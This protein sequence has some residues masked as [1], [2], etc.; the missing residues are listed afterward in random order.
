LTK[1]LAGVLVGDTKQLPPTVV[2]R[3]A[4]AIGLQRSLIERLELLGVEPY[5]LE[6][7]YRMHPGLAAFSSVRFYDRRLKSVPKP[8]ERVAPNGVNWPSTMVPLAFVEVKGEE[9]RAPDGNSIFNVQEAEEC[10]RV[11][12]KLLLS[13]DV[14]NAGDIGIIAPYAAQVRA[15]SEEWNR[16]VTSDVKLKNTSIVEA[17][18]P[19]SAKD[20]LEIRSVD[21]FQG[22]EKEVIVLCTVRNNRQNQ[23]GFVADPRRLNVAITRAKRGLI[24]LGHRDTLST[25]QLWQKWLQFVDKYECEVES[26]DVFLDES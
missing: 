14:K 9:M 13:G 17:D 4:V 16:K 8:S 5:L 6:E 20:E 7:Q 24:V 22:R 19:E 25:D 2:S 12:Q 10:V 3:D 23:L 26:A 1:A 18:N 15:I 21:G 11:V